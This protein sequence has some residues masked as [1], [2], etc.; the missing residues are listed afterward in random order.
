MVK[1]GI[2]LNDIKRIPSGRGI[3][4]KFNGTWIV[5]IYAPSGTEKKQEREHFYNSE[6][7]YIFTHDICRNNTSGRL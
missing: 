4:A 3:A 1:E 6:L 7:T 2:T 5:N